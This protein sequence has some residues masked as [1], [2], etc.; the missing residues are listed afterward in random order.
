MV[1][2]RLMGPPGVIASKLFCQPTSQGWDSGVLKQVDFFIFRASPH[3]LN[4]DLVYPAPSSVHADFYAEFNQS[5][6]PFSGGGFAGLIKVEN[7]G[8]RLAWSFA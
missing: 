8:D 3:S 7:L 4:E 1:V 6:G 2:Q 5:S